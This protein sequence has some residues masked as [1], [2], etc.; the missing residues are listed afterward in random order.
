MLSA[1]SK[2]VSILLR[3][4]RESRRVDVLSRPQI[5]TLDNQP[6][7]I[8]VG[9]RVPRIVGS[10]VNQNG[11]S[12]SVSLENVGLILGVTPRVSPDGTVV[13]EIDAEKSAL[14]AEQEGIPIAVSTDGT[15][16]RSPRVDTTTAQ[17]TVSAADGETIVL[18]GLITENDQYI[19]RSVPVLGDIPVLE[20]FFRYDSLIKRRTELLIILTPHVIRTAE[21][22]ARLRQLEMARMSWCACDVYRLMD[23]IDD[24]PQSNLS[25]VDL[26]QPQVIYPDLNP[27][28]ELAP[29]DAG[30]LTPSAN[31]LDLYSPGEVTGSPPAE[32]VLIGGESP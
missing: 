22:N 30:V 13:M 2:N 28:G 23:G 8:Q 29:G 27:T 31:K 7:F 16:I 18:G 24:M 25:Q 1:S 4:L 15:V 11:Q 14:G 12:N 9:Q 21:D 26:G 17:A 19:H 20:H 5:R 3:A 32:R 6:A 10:T